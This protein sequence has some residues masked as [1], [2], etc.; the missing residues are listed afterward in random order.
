MKISMKT[1]V[2][3]CSVVVVV[4]CR[5]HVSLTKHSYLDIYFL[6]C[7]LFIVSFVLSIVVT[8]TPFAMIITV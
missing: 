5:R 3:V 2:T 1:V 8:F 7:I 4:W 6:S